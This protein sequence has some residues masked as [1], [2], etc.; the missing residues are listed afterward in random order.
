VKVDLYLTFASGRLIDFVETKVFRAVKS[1]CSHDGLSVY[2]ERME[3]QREMRTQTS[4]GG[5]RVPTFIDV[6]LGS[7]VHLEH[8]LRLMQK[9]R[10]EIL[11][12][13]GIAAG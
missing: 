8:C 11:F 7:R 13:V 5:P 10:G 6:S 1:E 3:A 2:G 12:A 9:F 4:K